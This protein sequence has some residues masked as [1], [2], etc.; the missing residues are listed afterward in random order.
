MAKVIYDASNRCWMLQMEASTYCIGLNVDASSLQ[1]IYWGPRITEAVASEMARVRTMPWASFESV[2][3]LASEEYVPWGELRYGE[4]SLKVEYADGTRVIEWDV[5]KHGVERSG[6]SQLL[7]LRFRDRVYPL[8]VTLCYRIYDGQDVIERW[9]R[10][11]NTG[12]HGPVIIEQ[13][14]SADWRLPRREC[15]RLTYLYGKHERETQLAEVILGPGKMVLESR[16]GITSHQS[17]PW[18]ALDAEG[19][20]TEESRGLERGPGLEWF[21]EDCGGDDALWRS[22]LCRWRERF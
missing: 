22:S 1:H 14:L 10:L 6:A 11:E 2:T 8:V 3:G 21:V 20:A 19:R 18:V 5:E 15:Y 17:N 4:P 13:A 16:R 12:A 9:I 7:W